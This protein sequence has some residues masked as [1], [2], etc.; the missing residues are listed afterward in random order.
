MMDERG[1]SVLKKTILLLLI[2]CFLLFAAS[3]DLLDRPIHLSPEKTVPVPV[4][5]VAEPIDATEQKDPDLVAEPK[6]EDPIEQQIEEPK[7]EPISAQEETAPVESEDSQS[8]TEPQPYIPP[9]NQNFGDSNENAQD[10]NGQT[11]SQQNQQQ[12]TVNI[13]D[14]VPLQLNDGYT[15]NFGDDSIWNQDDPD[16]GYQDLISVN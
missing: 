8:V 10:N 13:E 3:C 1:A 12:G 9:I 4:D 16:G 6:T 2:L 7:S 15:I 14:D 5:E 11:D